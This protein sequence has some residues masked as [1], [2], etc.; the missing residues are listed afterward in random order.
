VRKLVGLFVFGPDFD[1]FLFLVRGQIE[2]VG[3]A[4]RE[5]A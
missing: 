2:G 1:F 5:E 4:W 3:F